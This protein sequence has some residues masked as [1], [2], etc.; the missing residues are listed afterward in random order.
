MELHSKLAEYLWAGALDHVEKVAPTLMSSSR[1]RNSVGGR[2]PAKIKGRNLGF[3]CQDA[4][5]TGV[6]R[7]Y[8]GV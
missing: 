1:R 7:R 2:H 4:F 8:G 3:L 5:K 6:S